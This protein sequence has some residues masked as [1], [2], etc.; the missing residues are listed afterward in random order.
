MKEFSNTVTLN[1]K[2]HEAFGIYI[3]FFHCIWVLSEHKQRVH[4]AVS[5][6]SASSGKKISVCFN[7]TYTYSLFS[8]RR[9]LCFDTNTAEESAR[10]QKEG[11]FILL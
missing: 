11:G 6:S 7:V 2:S 4:S 1:E 8:L 3:L 10:D 9:G 5:L